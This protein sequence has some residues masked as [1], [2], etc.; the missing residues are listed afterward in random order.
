MDC[1]PPAAP[2]HYSKKYIVSLGPRRCILPLVGDYSAN[3]H[4]AF[5]LHKVQYIGNGDDSTFSL[6]PVA[7]YTL[8]AKGVKR[9]PVRVRG[10]YKDNITLYVSFFVKLQHG[11]DADG[12]DCLRL[13][14]VVRLKPVLVWKG[15]PG[16]KIE[17]QL[18]RNEKAREHRG[19]LA[20][21]ARCASMANSLRW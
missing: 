2:H 3:L 10:R 15:K 4:R 20:T 8:D 12:D 7:K 13:T 14:D 18:K 1:I 6:E 16:G 17:K 11:I 21:V 19:V 5:R 9:V